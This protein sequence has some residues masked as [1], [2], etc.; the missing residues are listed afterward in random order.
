N[1]QSRA[2]IKQHYPPTSTSKETWALSLNP[3]LFLSQKP[4][5]DI[6]QVQYVSPSLYQNVPP[7]T[8]F[9][10]VDFY[11]RYVYSISGPYKTIF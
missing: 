3:F 7:L 11:H 2:I 5:T 4:I 6:I 1:V 10:A 9:L 8:R